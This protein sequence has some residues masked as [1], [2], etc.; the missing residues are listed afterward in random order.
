MDDI[1]III[2]TLVF[3]VLAFA[4][5]AKRKRQQEVPAEPEPW[6]DI[7][8]EMETAGTPSPVQPGK[9]NTPVPG[10]NTGNQPYP[11][12]IILLDTD[13][14]GIRNEMV[15]SAVSEKKEENTILT[16]EVQGEEGFSLRKAV[17]YSIILNPKYF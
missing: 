1:I 5:Q 8:R 17:I 12:R 15:V 2:L 7:F 9:A 13:T 11:G 6:G 10:K 16:P 3:T 14:E 4:N